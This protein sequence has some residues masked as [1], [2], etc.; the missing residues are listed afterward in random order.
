ML[1]KTDDA[2]LAWLDSRAERLL[3]AVETLL[4]VV[5]PPA[6]CVTFARVAHGPKLTCYTCSTYPSRHLVKHGALVSS[7]SPPEL[8]NANSSSQDDLATTTALLDSYR[9]LHSCALFL[10]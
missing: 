4:E 2:A 1:P 3:E 8:D 7:F 6:P 9:S 5:Q 10:R